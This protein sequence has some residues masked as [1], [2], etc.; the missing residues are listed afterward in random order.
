MAAGGSG[1]RERP[2]RYASSH[3]GT[4]AMLVIH[5]GEAVP[6]TARGAAVTI[7]VFD[8]VHRGHQA[9]LAQVRETAAA[10]DA[11]C[12]V[13][14]FDRHPATVVRPESAPRLLTTLRH[15]LE[16]FA[17]AGVDFVRVLTFD[18]ERSLQSAGDFAGSVLVEELAVGAVVIGEG[19]HF[20]LRRRGDVGALGEIADRYGIALVAVPPLAD[21]AS[22][23]PLS[24]SLV[25]AALA[26]GDVERAT[27]LL[28]RPYEVRGVVETG[29]RRGRLLGY[30][31]ANVAVG[32][33]VMLPGDGVYAGRY[34][35]PDGT[36]W[37]AA[38]SI[39]RRPTFYEVNGLLLV[40]AF[41]IDFDDDLY[42]QR[43]GVRLTRYI[44]SQE[45]FDS[46]EALT[47]QMD[48][49]LVIIRSIEGV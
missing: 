12:G 37:P 39:G 36:D 4:L 14:T 17:A 44:R 5:D 33:D 16:L 48:N 13:I 20:G 35:F 26:A 45:R 29:D 28:A 6:E 25:R 42:G 43:A 15:R 30:P 24:S 8:G 3:G 2:L 7:G 10:L 23:Q 46:A 22:G 38:I 47:A 40:E 27:E 41:L 1:G 11:P 21:T 18:E 34:V 49:D 31:T 19:F 32:G 9:L